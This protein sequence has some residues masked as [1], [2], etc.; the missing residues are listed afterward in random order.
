MLMCMCRC[1][2]LCL[3]AD[4]WCR[5]LFTGNTQ[6][7]QWT[8]TSL[9]PTHPL[10][11]SDLLWWLRRKSFQATII[12][13]LDEILPSTFWSLVNWEGNSL[14]I[15]TQQRKMSFQDFPR[16]VWI[17][18]R[19]ECEGNFSPSETTFVLLIRPLLCEKALYVLEWLSLCHTSQ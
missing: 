8:E 10:L 5:L 17:I 9:N 18:L 13:S 3:C 16:K 7:A 12:A 2:G 4:S 14:A 11:T 1:S 19:S 6:K 15:C